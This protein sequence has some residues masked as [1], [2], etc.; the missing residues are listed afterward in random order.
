MPNVKNYKSLHKNTTRIFHFITVYFAKLGKVI[1][2]KI[3]SPLDFLPYE[4]YSRNINFEI[5][6][7]FRLFKLIFNSTSC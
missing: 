3:N 2:K 7:Y 5:L 6:S 1:D 4:F